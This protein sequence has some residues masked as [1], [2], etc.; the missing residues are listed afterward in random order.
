MSVINITS[1]NFEKE[2]L[3]S[4]KPVL[5]DFWAEWC[6]PCK[7]L[8]PVIDEI[9][10]EVENVKFAKI[11]VDMEQGLAVKYNVMNIPTLIFFKDGKS[12][13]VMVGVRE[14][15]EILEMIK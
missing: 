8:S 2:I 11:N 15:E 6:T 7:M 4:E 10:E 9:S 3:N 1:D 12:E 13:E 14:K 5:V